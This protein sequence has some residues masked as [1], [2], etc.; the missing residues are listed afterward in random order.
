MDHVFS[1]TMAQSYPL[2]FYTSKIVLL[3][4]LSISNRNANLFFILTLVQFHFLNFNSLIKL[5]S[6][7]WIFALPST[8]LSVLP[9]FLETKAWRVLKV[10]SV[11]ATG[12]YHLATHV[13]LVHFQWRGWGKGSLLPTALLNSSSCLKNGVKQVLW[14]CWPSAICVYHL[15]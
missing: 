5:S 15:I 11:G 14:L 7:S 2:P 10:L 1:C 4:L 9:N 8:T 3:L 6:L 13:L 12:P